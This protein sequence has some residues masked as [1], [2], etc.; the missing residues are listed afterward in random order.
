M[1]KIIFCQE[2]L[3]YATGVIYGKNVRQKW[4]QIP[5]NGQIEVHKSLRLSTVS[6]PVFD[7][8]I[9]KPSST[10]LMELFSENY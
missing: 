1:M 8:K 4:D 5:P 2:K 7:E 6:T 10:A 9:Y 3:C